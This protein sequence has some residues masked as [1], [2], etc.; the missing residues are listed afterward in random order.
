MG[1]DKSRALNAVTM[2]VTGA[3]G[4]QTDVQVVANT[5]APYA[6]NLIGSQ[7]EH[8]EDKNKAAQ[9]ASH[10]ILGATFRYYTSSEKLKEIVHLHIFF[11]SLRHLLLKVIFEI[12][13]V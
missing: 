13:V 2:A 5:L 12:R 8:G 6:A 11:N 4:G 3:L 9:L 10:A 1:G 7:F